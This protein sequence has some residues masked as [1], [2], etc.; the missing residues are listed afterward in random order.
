MWIGKLIGEI[1][2]VENIVLRWIDGQQIKSALVKQK[3]STTTKQKLK[4][5]A[6]NNEHLHKHWNI[7]TDHTTRTT[8][9]KCFDFQ[10][11]GYNTMTASDQEI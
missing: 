8:S 11:A 7:L 9:P 1:K 3:L 5:I 6:A 2:R 10:L 4:L